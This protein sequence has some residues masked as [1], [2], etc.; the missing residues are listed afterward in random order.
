MFAALQQTKN[1]MVTSQISRLLSSLTLSTIIFGTNT[2]T[3]T[4]IP[5]LT[6]T[7]PRV[8]LVGLDLARVVAVAHVVGSFPVVVLDA[9]VLA[10]FPF[11]VFLFTLGHRLRI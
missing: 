8:Y 1:Q 2:L 11:T 7:Q 4:D 6:E 10:Q 9:V 3:T 5:H